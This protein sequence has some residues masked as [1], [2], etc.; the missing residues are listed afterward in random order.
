MLSYKNYDDSTPNL[1]NIYKSYIFDGNSYIYLKNNNLTFFLTF[2]FRINNQHE[3]TLLESKN[4]LIKYE[5]EGNAYNLNVY[6]KS[7]TNAS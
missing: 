6:I 3:F 2:L 7:V 5:I 1:N 4:L